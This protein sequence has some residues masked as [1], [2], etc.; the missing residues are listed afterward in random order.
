MKLKQIRVDGYKNLINCEVNLGDFNVLVGPN[1]SGKSQSLREIV[2]ICQDGKTDSTL[3]V[4]S[5]KLSKNGSADDLKQFLEEE[6]NYVNVS[7]RYKSWQIHESHIARW[8]QDYLTGNLLQG[9]IKNVDAND[10]LSIC[11]QQTSISPDEQKSKPQHVLY[12][13]D[14]LMA[15]ISGIFKRAFSKELMFE[16]NASFKHLT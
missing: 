16:P 8:N 13:D 9:F 4:K 14:S 6:A 2:A 15:K 11:E 3:V 10:R 1:N 12:D 7:Y 5:L